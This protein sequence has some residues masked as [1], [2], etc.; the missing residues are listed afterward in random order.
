MGRKSQRQIKNCD[1]R[2]AWASVLRPRSKTRAAENSRRRCGHARG[3]NDAVDVNRPIV[4]SIGAPCHVAKQDAPF[5][6]QCKTSLNSSPP[7]AGPW[8]QATVGQCALGAWAAQKAFLRWKAARDLRQSEGQFQD[9]LLCSQRARRALAA[10]LEGLG[11]CSRILEKR[12]R[13]T[14]PQRQAGH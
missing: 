14:C 2:H 8:R 12:T 5:L 7:S 4:A 13:E 9:F 10:T 1:H 3:L 6:L 11:G